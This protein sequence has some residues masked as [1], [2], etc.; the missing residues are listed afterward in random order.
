[1]GERGRAAKQGNMPGYFD[2]VFGSLQILQ[3]VIIE[4]EPRAQQP[5]VYIK[6]DL[7]GFRTLQFHKADDIYRQAQPAKEELKRKLSE[8]LENAGG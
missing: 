3:Q 7:S 5:D 1:M 4:R 6:P 8:K 2:T